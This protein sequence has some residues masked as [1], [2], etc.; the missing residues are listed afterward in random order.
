MPN[1]A[2]VFRTCVK[3]TRFGITVTLVCSGSVARTI[4]FVSWSNATIRIGS[5]ISRRRTGSSTARGALSP[6][7][8]LSP[9]LPA[10]TA[11]FRALSIDGFGQ[12]LLTPVAEAGPGR[13]ARHRRHVAP[14]AL[15]LHAGRAL[16]GHPRPRVG[17]GLAIVSRGGRRPQLDLGDDEQHREVAG[18]AFEKRE[19]GVGG[20]DDHAGLQRAADAFILS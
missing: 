6:R 19:L 5:Q 9:G 20:R 8:A 15:A 1:A 3:S 14:A 17:V 18:I 4:A 11:S 7:A 2:P 13:I 16:D 12:C 10:A